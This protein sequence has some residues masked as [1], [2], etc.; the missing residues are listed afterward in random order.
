MRPFSNAMTGPHK[1]LLAD[2]RILV[3]DDFASMRALLLRMVGELGGEVAQTASDGEEAVS[4]IGA[5]RFDV[6]LCDYNLGDGKNG[7]QVL[8]EARHRGLLGHSCVF[9]MITAESQLAMVLGAIEHQPDEYLIKPFVKE[10]LLLRLQRAIARKKDLRPLD[11][12]LRDGDYAAALELCRQIAGRDPG[13]LHDMQKLRAELY[14]GMGDYALAAAEFEQALA[15]RE[16]PWARFGLGRVRTLQER[17]G[18]ARD[19]FET[20]I[21]ANR[22]FPEAYDWLARVLAS[23]GDAAGAGQVLESA[24]A[25]SPR[26]VRRQR[27]LGQTAL[28]CDRFEVA[29]RAFASAI[30]Q[31]RNSSLA[32][33]AEYVGLAQVHSRK[34]APQAALN[35]LQQAGAAFAQEPAKLLRVAAGQA[36]LHR[37]QGDIAAAGAALD[38][39]LRLSTGLAE[40]LPAPAAIDLAGLCFAL[41]RREEGME[42]MQAAVRSGHDDEGTLAQARAAFGKA[43]LQAEGDALI[44]RERGELVGLNN[45]GVALFEQHRLDEAME[46]FI[47]AAEGLPLNRTVNLNAARILL[48]AMRAGGATAMRLQRVRKYLERARPA[49]EPSAEYA[50]ALSTLRGILG[51]SASTR[52]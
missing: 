10:V 2:L 14:I 1:S 7:Q 30:Q 43:G 8:E 4:L 17:Y 45:R 18:E 25:V 49:G 42:L 48:F 16:F 9:I 44:E 38:Q 37:G 20:L 33:P 36:R 51:G 34:G 31:G 6:V 23:Q 27:Q 11:L 12:A 15:V 39:A 46:L 3:V 24:V 13:R 22:R 32:D 28:Q 26:S 41:D 40:H 47:R 21:A 5:G 52:P 19:I 50:S 35:V 29:E